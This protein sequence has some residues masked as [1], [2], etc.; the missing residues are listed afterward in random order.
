M[1][2]KL[3]N[4]SKHYTVA[5]QRIPALDGVTLQLGRGEYVALVGRSGCGKTT[6]L[7]LAGAADLP[8]SGQVEIEGVE[9]SSLDDDALTRLRRTRIGF[10]FQFL[11]LLPSLSAVENVEL[12]LQLAGV[13]V[14][15][16]RPRA[17]R[18]MELA[19]VAHLADR[20][21]H[22]LSGGQMQCVA[23]ARALVHDPALLLA[24]EPTGRLDTQTADTV[25]DLLFEI[26]SALGTS[27]LMATHNP[28]AAAACDRRLV[29][30]NGTLV[31]DDTS[32]PRSRDS[33]P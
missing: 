25:M 16:A 17:L 30:S 19:G 27:V 24:D 10:V 20:R 14:R 13:R 18:L 1:V 2:L 33:G 8:S 3:R 9:T 23:I 26:R 5:E 22:Q 31:G 29:L 4:V 7:N 12:P 15:S 32:T 21:P 28:A 11:Q 6:L